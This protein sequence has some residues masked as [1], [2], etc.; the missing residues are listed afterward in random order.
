MI[1]LH[2]AVMVYCG[3]R[4]RTWHHE[5]CLFG[6]WRKRAVWEFQGKYIIAHQF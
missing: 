1:N 2:T 5:R 3:S 6:G 4:G